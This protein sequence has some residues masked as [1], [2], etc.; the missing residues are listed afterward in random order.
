MQLHSHITFLMSKF[1]SN[2]SGYI[3]YE[4]QI[5]KIMKYFKALGDFDVCYQTD[6]PYV[7]SQKDT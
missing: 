1:F 6:Y 3:Y 4:K 7:F 5:L 2:Q